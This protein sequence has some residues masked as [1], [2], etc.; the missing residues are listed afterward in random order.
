MPQLPEEEKEERQ[1]WEA[2][3]EVVGDENGRVAEEVGGGR[4]G[5]DARDGDN[6][7]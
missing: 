4:I 6:I 2:Y 3:W 5:E 1:Q 7:G